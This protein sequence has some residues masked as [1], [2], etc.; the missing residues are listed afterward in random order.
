MTKP[1]PTKQRSRTRTRPYVVSMARCIRAA[2]HLNQGSAWACHSLTEFGQRRIAEKFAA[3]WVG[4][5]VPPGSLT[6]NLL[7]AGL[8]LLRIAVMMMTAG[9]EVA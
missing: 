8:G 9:L 5:F 1:R 4:R 2:G 6:A 7:S 3:E